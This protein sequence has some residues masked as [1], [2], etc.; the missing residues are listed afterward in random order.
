MGN[1]VGRFLKQNFVRLL[2]GSKYQA[3]VRVMHLINRRT[4]GQECD[5][6]PQTEDE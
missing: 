6:E 3:G 1:L 4:T 5:G 2:A